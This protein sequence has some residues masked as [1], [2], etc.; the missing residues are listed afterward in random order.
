MG[1]LFRA[2]ANPITCI[3]PPQWITTVAFHTLLLNFIKAYH[4]YII[5][6]THFVVGGCWWRLANVYIHIPTEHHSNPLPIKLLCAGCSQPHATILAPGSH[7]SDFYLCRLVLLLLE[8]YKWNN[9]V[10]TFVLLLLFIL[11]LLRLILMVVYISS[12]FFYCRVVFH[13]LIII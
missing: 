3:P 5:K 1:N 2:S 11:R 8:S 10:C 7:W 6:L 12:L 13:C 9:T 4:I